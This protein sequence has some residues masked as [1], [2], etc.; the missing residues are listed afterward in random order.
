MINNDLIF[1]NVT[2]AVGTN[3]TLNALLSDD[4]GNSIGSNT[5]VEGKVGYTDVTFVF[6][7]LTKMFTV[8][9]S[10]TQ[11]VGLY[12]ITG[13]YDLAAKCKVIA[14]LLNVQSIPNFNDS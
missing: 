8:K 1:N 11:T 3:T 4:K 14:G 12:L 9:Y 6:D 2:C 13:S 10:Q 7:E 5:L